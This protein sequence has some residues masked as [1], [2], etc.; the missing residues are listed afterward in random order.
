MRQLKIADVLAD[1]G[2]FHLGRSLMTPAGMAAH[3]HDFV[4]FFWVTEGRGV[5]RINDR[6]LPLETGDLV[7]IRPPDHHGF[8]GLDTG[9]AVTN[10]AFAVKHVAELAACYP[11]V[12]A[13]W[14]P[15]PELPQTLRL[16]PALRGQ[17]DQATRDLVDRRH[18]RL[19]LDAF[20]LRLVEGLTTIAPPADDLP[21]WLDAALMAIRRPAHFRLGAAEFVRLCGR[22]HEHVTR[23]LR[24]RTG[25]T[26]SALIT[27]LRMAHAARRLSL[28]DADILTI[29]LD[30]GYQSLG[31]FYAAFTAQHATTPARY[32]HQ[33]SAV[34]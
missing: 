15:E 9:M 25:Q 34:F 21:P 4:E 5:H 19:A 33:Q 7:F 24:A 12:G 13:Y 22:S 23:V 28:T 29:A 3:S 18:S 14:R 32:R 6:E 8:V 26:P 17:M 31:Q 10:I 20:L 27:E 1:G 11:E 16:P 30:C 2:V